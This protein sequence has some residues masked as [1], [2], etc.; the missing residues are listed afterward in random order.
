M[1]ANMPRRCS[2][3]GC[4]ASVSLHSGDFF[5]TE[6]YSVDAR[7]LC[8]M[9]AVSSAEHPASRR[10]WNCYEQLHATLRLI[11]SHPS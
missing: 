10:H 11:L 9:H 8:T 3:D 5:S 7:Q 4:A 2:T 1:V 6:L